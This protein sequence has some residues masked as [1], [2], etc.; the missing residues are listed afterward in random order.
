MVKGKQTVP[1]NER[2][3]LQR[4]NRVL[5][6]RYETLKR[7]RGRLREELGRFYLLDLNHNVIRDR[8]A[9]L[10]ALGRELGCLKEWEHLELPAKGAR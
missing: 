4:V 3:L 10:E 8:S 7:P 2:A 9:D 5:A 6:K 1:V